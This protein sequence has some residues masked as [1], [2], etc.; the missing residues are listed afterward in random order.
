MGKT[1]IE[2]KQNKLRFLYILTVGN[3]TGEVTN[4]IRF[5]SN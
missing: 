1:T 3:V 4:S 2:Q 5:G